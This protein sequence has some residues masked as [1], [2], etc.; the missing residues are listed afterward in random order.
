MRCRKVDLVG[1]YNCI[2]STIISLENRNFRILSI[3]L[4]RLPVISSKLVE[5]ET[6]ELIEDSPPT[7][8][9]GV[10]IFMC[11]TPLLTETSLKVTE[12]NARIYHK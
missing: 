1:T 7:V 2:V 5:A 10:A 4:L 3:L 8:R 11:E 12:V 9:S 6:M